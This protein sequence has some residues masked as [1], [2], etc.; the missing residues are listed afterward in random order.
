V[1][2]GIPEKKAR[3]L[4]E[5]MEPFARYGFN[6]SHSAAYAYI[7][8]RT[9]YLKTHFPVEFMAATLSSDTDNTDKIV[10][11]IAEC[12]KMSIDI[13][14]PDINQSG[15][16]FRV[17]GKAIRFGLEAVKGVGGAAIES[18]LDVREQD[19]LF[20]SMEDFLRRVDG[21]K[22]NKKV[23]ESL[24]KAGA[25]DSFGMLR[26]RAL[27]MFN[28]AA[29]GDASM[30]SL[31]D[32]QNIFGEG[33]GEEEEEWDEMT[34]LRYE[35]DALGF[36]ITGHPLSRYREA[37]SAMKIMRMSELEES[38]DKE[39]V[40]VAGVVSAIKKIK[41]KGRS[42]SMA[43]LTLE[44]EEGSAEVIVFPELYKTMAAVLVKESLVTVKG[45]VDKTEKGIKIVSRE[46]TG[47]EDLIARNGAQKMEITLQKNS[48]PPANLRA[49]K[50]LLSA[51]S[52]RCLLYLRIE[53]NG[54][55]AVIA[56]GLRVEP[57]GTL[58]EKIEGFL[59]KGMVKLE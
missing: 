13:L 28:N 34:L 10:K 57:S 1:A 52:G 8:Y 27:A 23:V 50:E 7:A 26:A 12:R 3:K 39:E 42:E 38:T 51:S 29:N 33:G 25:F 41:T 55:C 45:T 18:M 5:K 11:S 54:S 35:K 44:D 58:L 9:A 43:Y 16:E 2:N 20:T 19:G 15:K 49:L 59:G 24:I 56:T 46:V 40:Q 30:G 37:L 21:R 48:L 14:P 32:Q 47:L 22:V 6:K 17:S 31:F 36:Y 53:V 4:F